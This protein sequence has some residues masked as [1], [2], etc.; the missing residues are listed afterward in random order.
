MGVPY[1]EVIGDPIAHSK[2][3]SIHEFWLHQLGLDGG[4]GASQVKA[5]GDGLSI[6][7]NLA[8]RDPDWMGCNVTAPHKR[9]VL[10]LVDRLTPEASSIG[11]ANVV[12]RDGT[13]LIGHNTDSA[14]FLEPLRLLLAQHHHG[15]TAV[16]IGAGGAARAVA[17]ALIGQDFTIAVAARDKA[18]ADALLSELNG[19]GY[20]YALSQL[21][22]PA[23]FGFAGGRAG[24]LDLL[25]NATPA[26]MEGRQPLQL[27]WDHFP[28]QTV[29]Y[30]LV[31][32]PPNTPLLKAAQRR[33]HPVIDGLGMLIAQAAL[34]FERFFGQPAPREHDAELRAL[35]TA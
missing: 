16:I 3:P 7:L 2:S 34:A 19:V 20:A 21:E 5:K 11:A 15:R 8:R 14:G 13:T 4:Y 12:F 6:Y 1:A 23:L 27:N 31:Y 28:A 17:H 24:L 22:Q 32:A 9:A 10:P 25:V 18:A 29:A 30:D 26:G 33:G 35:I